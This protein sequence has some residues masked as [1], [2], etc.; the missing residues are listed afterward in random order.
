MKMKR[1]SHVIPCSIGFCN[2]GYN[3]IVFND[4]F[5]VTC[6]QNG[7]GIKQYFSDKS[8]ISNLYYM[9][10]T[11]GDCALIREKWI[12][13]RTDKGDYRIKIVTHTNINANYDYYKTEKILTIPECIFN[14]CWKSDF[15]L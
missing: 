6:G 3:K 14:A 15:N 5:V 7:S 13:G 2:L 11:D 12:L 1:F 9:E 4:G 10:L 8:S